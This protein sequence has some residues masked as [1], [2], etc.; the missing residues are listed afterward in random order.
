MDY[1]TLDQ[2]LSGRNQNGRKLANNTYAERRGDN[3]AIRLHS[4][5]VIT[6]K[7]NGDKVLSSGGWRTATTK[8][9]INNFGGVRMYQTNGNWYIGD[10]KFQD[11]MT[12]KANGVIIGGA[13]DNPKS[14]K[15]FKSRVGAFAHKCANAI[16]LDPPGNGDCLYC[17]MVTDKNGT[18]GDA[19]KNNEHLISHIKESYIVPSLVYQALKEINAGDGIMAGTFTKDAGFYGDIAKTYVYRAVRRYI[20]RRFGYA[21]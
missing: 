13:K 21:S 14:D 19:T 8:D 11:G 5:D 7:P 2:R 20:L 3:I 12:I 6:F 18:L 1:S 10:V 17:H 4:T 15:V 9:R 16:P